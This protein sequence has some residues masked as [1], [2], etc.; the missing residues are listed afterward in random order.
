MYIYNIY[1]HS[2]TLSNLL[3]VAVKADGGDLE[4][5]IEVVH[6]LSLTSKRTNIFTDHLHLQFVNGR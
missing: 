3:G 2:S 1:T 5:G 6:R 4:I